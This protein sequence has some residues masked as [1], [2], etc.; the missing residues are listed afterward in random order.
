MH[1]HR[2]HIHF[3]S[4]RLVFKFQFRIKPSDIAVGARAMRKVMRRSVGKA[5]KE[6]EVY[7]PLVFYYLS[8]ELLRYSAWLNLTKERVKSI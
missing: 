2:K 7:A 3:G 8:C 6:S 4:D 5:K 1:V